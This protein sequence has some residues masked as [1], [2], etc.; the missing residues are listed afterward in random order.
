MYETSHDCLGRLSRGAIVTPLWWLE[1][2]NAL[3]QAE[4]RG[5]ITA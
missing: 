2:F 1:I 5:R 3:I 4:K